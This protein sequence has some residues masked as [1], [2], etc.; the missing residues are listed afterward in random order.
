MQ[1]ISQI[2]LPCDLDLLR[3]HPQAGAAAGRA[4]RVSAIAAEK[5]AHVQLV[6]LAFEMIEE[7]AHAR[8]LAFAIDNHPAL[9]G[10]EFRPGNIQGNIRLLGKALQFSEQRAIFGLGPGLDGALIQRLRFVGNHQVEIEIDGVAKTLAART[11]AIRIIEGKQAR[12]RFFVAQIALLALKALGKP[13][14]LR[15][16][17]VTW[18]G[19]KDDLTG[20][21]IADFD[22]IHD[23]GASVRSYDQPVHQEEH[24]LAEIDVEQGLGRGEFEDLAVLVEAVETAL[25]QTGEARF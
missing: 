10:L 22:G 17:I 25:A 6:F 3:L 11:C 13:Q 15:R 24:R 2:F 21:A 19:L 18:G 4:G 8:K 7:A 5:Y 12:L 9:L 23:T 20:F 16:L 14:L 1:V